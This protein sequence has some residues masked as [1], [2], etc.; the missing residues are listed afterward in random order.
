MPQA[1]SNFL[2]RIEINFKTTVVLGVVGASDFG[3]Q[4]SIYSADFSN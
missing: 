2:Y 4:I 1:L 3:Y